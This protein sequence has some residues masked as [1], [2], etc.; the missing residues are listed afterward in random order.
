MEMLVWTTERRAAP[1]G[2]HLGS[3]CA[4]CTALSLLLLKFSRELPGFL[5]YTVLL[6]TQYPSEHKTQLASYSTVEDEDPF[7]KRE[8][9]LSK[10]TTPHISEPT[11]KLGHQ[12]LVQ[13]YPCDSTVWTFQNV[14]GT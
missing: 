13:S 12:I 2:K 1:A 11:M 4:V 10:V 9:A 14:E 3:E 7:W 5:P 6:N 8:Y